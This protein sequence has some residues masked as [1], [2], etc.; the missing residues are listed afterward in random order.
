MATGG[1]KEIHVRNI[2][3]TGRITSDVRCSLVKD[4]VKF[5]L[6]H[7]EQIPLP[8]EQLKYYFERQENIKKGSEARK[9]SQLLDS[10][11]ELCSNLDLLFQTTSDVGQILILLGPTIAT[12]KEIFEIKFTPN[13]LVG[14]L[15]EVPS[16]KMCSR[17]LHKSLVTYNTLIDINP[18]SLTSMHILFHGQRSADTKWFK[19]K[20]NFKIPKRGQHFT[21][22]IFSKQ[23]KSVKDPCQPIRGDVEGSECHRKEQNGINIR[24]GTVADK[25]DF[26]WF[27]APTIIKG[28]KDSVLCIPQ[29]GELWVQ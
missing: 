6:Y 7:R 18:P 28:I 3:L 8:Y 11:Q 4:I 22:Q 24:E 12:P 25:E 26:L 23:S 17:L 20:H 21:F 2:E 13:P 27:M 16:C 29:Q 5:I 14:P 9:L 10:V 19:P 15:M 1:C